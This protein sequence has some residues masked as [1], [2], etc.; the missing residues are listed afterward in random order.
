M[1]GDDANSAM[2]GRLPRRL[3]PQPLT[4]HYLYFLLRHRRSVCSMI[5]LDSL[6]CSIVAWLLRVRTDFFDWYPPSHPYIQL[7]HQY[8]HLRGTANALQIVVEAAHGDIYTVETMKKID[9]ITR[10]QLLHGKSP[11][12]F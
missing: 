11:R 2:S 1:R 10:T 6:F 12:N 5:V 3:E 9:L 4:Q 7:Y 8:R